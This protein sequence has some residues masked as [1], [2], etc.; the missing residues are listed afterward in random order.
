MKLIRSDQ[1][2]RFKNGDTCT[3]IEYPM[4]EAD[5]NGA[6]IELSGRYPETGSAMNNRCK[7][8]AFVISGSGKVIVNGQEM[9][10]KKD[11]M[12]FIEPGEKYF[13]E[14]NLRLFMP[15]VPAWSPEQY[16]YCEND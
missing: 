10:L 11:D 1:T 13:W 3:A 6:V 9:I 8:L 16:R 15:S 14:G 12:V 4:G 7:L 2:E 5:I